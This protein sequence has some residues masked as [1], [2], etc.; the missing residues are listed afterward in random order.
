MSDESGRGTDM[1][2]GRA[3][4][5]RDHGGSVRLDRGDQRA[6][7]REQLNGRVRGSCAGQAWAGV[8]GNR[9]RRVPPL[10]AVSCTAGGA[11]R[12]RSAGL[13]AS[14]GHRASWMLHNGRTEPV[15]LQALTCRQQVGGI[16]GAAFRMRGVLH[17]G[18]ARIAG[19]ERTENSWFVSSRKRQE[20]GL[21]IVEPSRHGWRG[22]KLILYH[23]FRSRAAFP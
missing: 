20:S 1:A 15:E 17:L 14:D 5:E 12:G 8:V 3:A 22:G 4:R 9:R 2:C 16:T 23:R 7:D 6:V 10:S 11:V 13:R 19:S 18:H 21:R